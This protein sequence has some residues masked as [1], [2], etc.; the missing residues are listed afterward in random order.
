[1]IQLPN[2]LSTIR[3]GLHLHPSIPGRM[4]FSVLCFHLQFIF[5]AKFYG[6]KSAPTI[7]FI[8]Y[9]IFSPVGFV[10]MKIIG[11]RNGLRIGVFVNFRFWFTIVREVRESQGNPTLIKGYPHFCSRHS[12]IVLSLSQF[13]NPSFSSPTLTRPFHHQNTSDTDNWP[14]TEIYCL[15]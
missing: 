11:R 5:S 3:L 1:M 15:L 13:L 10:A 7:F 6:N 2:K 9:M 4:M 8:T 12:S 14:K